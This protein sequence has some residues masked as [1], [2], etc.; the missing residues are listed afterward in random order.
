MTQAI[1]RDAQNWPVVAALAAPS[2]D[3]AAGGAPHPG[4]PGADHAQLTARTAVA[5]ERSRIAGE[6]DDAACKSLLGIALVA[7]SLTAPHWSAD[8]PSLDDRLREL[9]RLA[10]QAVG[11]VRCVINDLRDDVLGNAVRSV[12]SAWG[13]VA[14]IRVTLA[15][16]Q[17]SDTT[18]EIRREVVAILRAALLN[19]EQHAGASQVRVS[20]QTGGGLLMVIADNGS[21]FSAQARLDEVKSA[22]RGGLAVMRE[23]VC[24]LGGNLIIRSEPGRGTRLEVRIPAPE[25]A[26]Q[27]LRAA[28]SAPP[29]RVVIAESNP[30]LRFG[31]RAVLGQSPA[32]EVV[33]EAATGSQAAEQ[34][35]LHD[36]DVLVLDARMSLP[37]GPATIRQ[38]SQLAQV[39]VLTWADDA[40]SVMPAVA[41]GAYVIP[42]EFEPGELIRLVLDA[43]RRGREAGCAPRRGQPGAPSAAEDEARSVNG[44]LRPRE[45]EIMQLIADGMSNRQIAARLVISEKTVKNHICSIYQRL[46]AHGRSQAISRWRGS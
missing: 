13:I 18:E 22:P 37:D 11:E 19:V 34:V 14:G 38:L 31:L 28:P 5:A 9:G 2:L 12:A 45:R 4:L 21:G 17:V 29:V 40:G 7:D 20:L 10:R 27:R 23:R 24:R 8:P 6:L 39:V 16:P 26:R 43:A 32:T 41:A 36:A 46:G 35:R 15:V 42:G 44:R 25:L 3:A 1:M 30:V 33:A